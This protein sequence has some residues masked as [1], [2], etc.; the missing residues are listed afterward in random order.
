M[1]PPEGSSCVSDCTRATGLAPY[2]LTRVRGIG[3]AA[4]SARLPGQAQRPLARRCRLEVAA[5]GLVDDD[6]GG[7]GAVEQVVGARPPVPVGLAGQ[8][9]A[10]ACAPERVAGG[11]G[12]ARIVGGQAGAG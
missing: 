10:D 3:A 12:R 5:V 8:Q 11:S 1:G 9:T 7:R 4:V 2:K 6:A